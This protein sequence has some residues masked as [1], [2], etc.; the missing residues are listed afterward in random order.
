MKFLF[1]AQ[2]PRRL[3]DRLRQSGVDAMHTLELPHGNR[4]PD[5]ELNELSITT[6][7]VLVTKDSDFVDSFLLYQQPWKLLLV[8]TGNI[9]NAELEA[10]FLENI[11]RMAEAFGSFDFIEINRNNLVFHF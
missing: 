7:R 9:S 8:S 1:D 10:L 6:Q 3:V 4:T 2:L 11:G 5:S